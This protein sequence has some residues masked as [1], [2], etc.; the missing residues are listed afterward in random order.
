MVGQGEVEEGSPVGGELHGGGQAALDDGQVAGGQVAVQ[1]GDEGPQL[2][3]LLLA[4]RQAGGVDAGAGDDDHPQLG[5]RSFGQREGVDDPAQERGADAGAA[6]GHH[7]DL[8]VGVVAEALAQ[9]L[10]VA[11]GG[12]VEAG[13]VAG[14]VVVGLGPVP[15]G[16][17]VRAEGVGDDVVGVA[18]EDGPVAQAG[19]AGDVLQHLGV[20]VGGELG[21]VLAAVGHGQPADEVGQPGVGGPFA[22]GVLVQVVVE[23]P[24]FVADHQVV[25]LLVE[26]VVDDHVVGQ[27]DLVHPPAGLEGSAGRARRPRTRC[28]RTRWPGGGWRDGSAR[29]R[30]P[31]PG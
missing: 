29:P 30:R 8:L 20:V 11:E 1:V 2:E 16:W 24:G 5:H 3:S 25:V 10:A 15:D 17:E 7:A 6:D 27:Q 19:V 21:L 12:G 9:L 4:G 13:D 22:F 23:L 28:G 18:D 14:E 31:G 26:Q